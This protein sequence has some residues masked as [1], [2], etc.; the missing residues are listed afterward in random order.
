M[1]VFILHQIV[2]HHVEAS[3]S[4]HYRHCPY[5]CIYP[6][7]LGQ[8]NSILSV[9]ASTASL[10][11]SWCSIGR[12]SSSSKVHSSNGFYRYVRK[13]LLS[14]TFLCCGN[15]CGTC[16][17]H[18]AFCSHG[19]TGRTCSAGKSRGL[20]GSCHLTDHTSSIVI[21]SRMHQLNLHW[22]LVDPWCEVSGPL[23]LL[24]L[25]LLGC[26]QWTQLLS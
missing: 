14:L 8:S 23:V 17:W 15:S 13:L 24:K 26:H 25:Y 5:L 21:V 7:P 3:L 12:D 2:I 9:E 10:P 4:N 20:V 16:S 11:F 6:G 18:S 1:P 22:I 19:S